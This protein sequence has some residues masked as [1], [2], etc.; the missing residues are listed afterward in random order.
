MNS[1]GHAAVGAAVG[2]IAYVGFCWLKDERPDIGGLLVCVGAGAAIACLPDLLEPAVH[3]NHRG[4]IHSVV[5]NAGLGVALR[6]LWLNA[7]S[8][9]AQRILWVSLGLAY[10]SH[11]AL[12]LMTPKGLP[13]LL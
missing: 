12:D 3:P 5:V 8:C 2:G 13:I 9:P 6:R 4:L 7:E 1:P 10:L 11:P